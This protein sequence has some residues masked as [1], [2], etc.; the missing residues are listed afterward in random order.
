MFKVFCCPSTT[1][2]HT[3]I[4]VKR[5][6]AVAHRGTG[7]FQLDYGSATLVGLPKQL[8]DRLQ[9]AQNAAARLIFKACRQDHIQPLL[10]RLHWLRMPERV[11]FRLAVLVYCCLHGSAPGYLAS[12]LQRVS[13]LNALRLHQRWSLQA[14]CVLLLATA[15]FQRLLH[16]SGTVCRSQSG[17]RHRCKFSAED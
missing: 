17:H 12:D 11:S 8:M 5:R 15:P 7:V 1:T 9:F 16:W 4:C 13:H 3:P 14:L 10:H 6:D 2:K